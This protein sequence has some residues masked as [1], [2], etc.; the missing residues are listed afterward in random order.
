MF[1]ILPETENRTLEDIELHFSDNSKDLTDRTIIKVSKMK[2]MHDI[3]AVNGTLII[4]STF[5][6][7]IDYK[8]TNNATKSGCD[9]KGFNMDFD[10]L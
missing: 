6:S 10:N 9:D 5:K 7:D 3:E 1:K 8:N 2:R 4:N